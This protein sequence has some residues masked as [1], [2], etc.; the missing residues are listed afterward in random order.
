MATRN[1]RRSRVRVREPRP[2]RVPLEQ[3]AEAVATPVIPETVEEVIGRPFPGIPEPAP[4]DVTAVV[5]QLKEAIGL[6]PA[7]WRPNQEQV[8]ALLAQLGAADEGMA[9]TM[10]AMAEES[11]STA[12]GSMLPLI[13]VAVIPLVKHIF[14]KLLKPRVGV[15]GAPGRMDPARP[16]STFRT[17][18]GKTGG[19]KAVR[20]AVRPQGAAMQ[21]ARSKGFSGAGFTSNAAA[22]M[23]ELL[24]VG[25]R[26]SQNISGQQGRGGL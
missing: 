12:F 17:E 21:A 25:A 7:R 3:V 1:S 15:L 20:G 19:E 14:T 9:N 11:V 13:P 18:S 8:N 24:A 5:G 10:R 26:R 2:A 23:N 6:V 22:R 16:A 4:A